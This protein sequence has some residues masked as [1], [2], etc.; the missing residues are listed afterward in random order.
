MIRFSTERTILPEFNQKEISS[1]IVQVAS[2]HNKKAGD[3]NYIFCDDSKIL[4]IN[5]LF[6]NHDYF[7]DIITFDRT[8]KTILA[9]DI[10]ISLE[11][12][13]SNARQLKTTFTNELN[14]VIIHGI[15]HLCG[16]N[17]K[18]ENEAINMRKQEETALSI[19]K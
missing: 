16:I 8:I 9:G 17:D 4:E 5:N 6:L 3:I 1:W 13:D 18:S 7:T 11:T 14:R 12:V 10:Y 19:L 15:L 2:M